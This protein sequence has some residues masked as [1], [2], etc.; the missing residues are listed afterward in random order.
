MALLYVVAYNGVNLLRNHS[1]ERAIGCPYGIECL[2]S[3]VHV[4]SV[5]S[6]PPFTIHKSRFLMYWEIIL[7]VLMALQFFFRMEHYDALIIMFRYP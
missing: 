5:K 7:T 1:A 2:Y 3:L 4:I 6:M